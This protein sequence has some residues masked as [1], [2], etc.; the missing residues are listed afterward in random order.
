MVLVHRNIQPQARN[1]REL[2]KMV[3]D[4]SLD[5]NPAYQRGDVWTVDQRVNLIRSML[6]GVPVAS[7]VLNRRGGNIDWRTNEGDPGEVWYACIDGKQRMTTMVMWRN[8]EV[9]IP[10]DWIADEYIEQSGET[11]SYLDLTKVGR[12]LLDNRFLIPIAEAQLG[13]VA[14]EAEV[15]DLINSAGTA[16]AEAD[17]AKARSL[18]G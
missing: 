11:V 4:G 1:M 10:S 13:S 17:L 15:Y 14:E 9:R 5:L 2:A 12:R 18:R 16:H 7:I 6:L 8:G 3:E